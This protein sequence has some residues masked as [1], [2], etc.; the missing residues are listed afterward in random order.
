VVGLRLT[1]A[2][3]AVALALTG[4][5]KKSDSTSTGSSGSNTASGVVGKAQKDK[6]LTIGIKY[7]QPGLGLKKPDGTFAGFDVDVATYI[8]KELGVDA[9]GI[10]FVETKSAEREDKIQKG[11]VDFIVATYSITDARKQKVDFAGPYYIAHQD[12][13]IKADDTSITG[14]DSLNSGNK[15]LCSVTGSTSAQTVKTKFAGSV[16]LQEYKGYSDCVNALLSGAVNALTTD[17][18]ILAGYAAQHT[19]QLKVVGK[20]FTDEKYG[21]GLK[22]GDTASKDAINNAIKK[23]FTDGAWVAALKKN[24]GDSFTVPTPP[25]I[26]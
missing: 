9:S 18:T 1:V 12:L 3:T 23:M 20:G 7:D 6:K 19:G 15:I 17:D 26:S 11:D 16:Q 8:A 2:A 5:S 14:P 25:T 4:C 21:V 13:L 22:Q 24:F 10:T